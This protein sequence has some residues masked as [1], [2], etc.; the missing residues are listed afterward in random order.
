MPRRGNGWARTVVLSAA[1]LL[2]SLTGC[3]GTG[4]G[5]GT[6]AE[7]A[8]SQGPGQSVTLDCAT[9]R[10]VEGARPAGAEDVVIGPLRYDGLA[11]GHPG[12]IAD[13]LHHVVFTTIG[14]ELLPDVTVTVSVA[15]Q[16]REWAAIATQPGPAAGAYSVTY[17]SCPATL[18]PQGVWWAGGFT[19]RHRTS[20]CLPLT[21]SIH[22]AA[23]PRHVVVSFWDKS[24][25]TGET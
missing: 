7:P 4:T 17:I 9:S 16:A 3:T 10:P 2:I 13:S 20:G 8:A 15:P 5:A 14:T 23:G 24:C 19:L 6:S 1:G 21:V 22:G 18:H 11:G 25:A 12:A